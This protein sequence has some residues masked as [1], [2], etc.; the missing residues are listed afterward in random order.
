LS[1]VSQQTRNLLLLALQYGSDELTPYLSNEIKLSGTDIHIYGLWSIHNR[2]HPGVNLFANVSFVRHPV[3]AGQIQ[4]FFQNLMSKKN[5]VVPVKH[6][7]VSSV[8]LTEFPIILSAV[9]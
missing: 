9:H 3:V 5:V 6:S 7:K 2:P 8:K 4:K 1:E